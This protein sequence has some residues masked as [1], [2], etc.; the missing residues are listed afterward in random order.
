MPTTAELRSS[1]AALATL[2][3]RDLE[4]IW[5]QVNDAAQARDALKDVLP[6]LVETYGAAAAA[7]AADW[8]DDL[9]DELGV[10]GRFA[11][12]P[13]EI[14]A[15]GGEALAGWAVTPLFSAEPDWA[16]AQSNVAGGLQ[17]RIANASRYTVAGSA[18]ADPAADGWQRAGSGTSCQFCRMLISRG[19]VYSEAGADFSS[20]DRCNC[21]AVPAFGG[22]P[23]PVQPYKQSERF[24]TQEARDVHNARTRAGMKAGDY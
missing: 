9:R 21:H 14:G 16:V 10:T 20:H 2:A 8:Y 3:A 23:R 15:T 19:A 12:I 5:R 18:V 24:R 11:A 6:A 1:V 22:L 13:A 4:E 17:R 7:L